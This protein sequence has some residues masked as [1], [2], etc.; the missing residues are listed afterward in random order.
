MRDRFRFLR[1]GHWGLLLAGVVA[2]GSLG[3]AALTPELMEVVQPR[4]GSV[5]GVGGVEIMIRFA[6]ESRVEVETF[7]VLLNGADATAE[8]TTGANGAYGRLHG[9]LDGENRL[10]F[11]AFGRRWWLPGRLVEEAREV[12]FLVRLPQGLDRG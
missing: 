5:I 10:R 9:L 2:A 8:F 11:E 4:P 12:R 7:R 1:L 3:L 6:P